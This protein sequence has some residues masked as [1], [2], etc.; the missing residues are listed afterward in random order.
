MLLGALLVEVGAGV[1]EGV[2][3]EVGAGEGVEPPPPPPPQAATINAIRLAEASFGFLNFNLMIL[4]DIYIK[5]M[6]IKCSCP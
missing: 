4:R 1:G 6:P 2:G 5:N 3:V